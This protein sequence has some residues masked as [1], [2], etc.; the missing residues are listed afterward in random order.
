MIQ[1]FYTHKNSLESAL[2]TNIFDQTTRE[3]IHNNKEQ[4]IQSL[5]FIFSLAKQETK[6]PIIRYIGA[7]LAQAISMITTTERISFD[8]LSSLSDIVKRIDNE[9]A[10]VISEN[11]QDARAINDFECMKVTERL[12]KNIGISKNPS[13]SSCKKRFLCPRRYAIL[14]QDVLDTI[15]TE[16]DTVLSSSL[17]ISND[18]QQ[19]SY[20]RFPD[21]LVQLKKIITDVIRNR[22]LLSS[23]KTLSSSVSLNDIDAGSDDDNEDKKDITTDHTS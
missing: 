4:C 14:S 2:Q 12:R 21:F 5:L 9:I 18:L 19:S 15:I 7:E 3:K 13:F 10:Y 20:Y 6:H 22:F 8:E 17:F 11:Q 1:E 23:K 16:I